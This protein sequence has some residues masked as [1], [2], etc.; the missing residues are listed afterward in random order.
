VSGLVQVLLDSGRPVLRRG[1]TLLA[2]R[3]AV[4]GWR[5]LG[6]GD[7]MLFWIRARP[8][9][10]RARRPGARGP[11]GGAA[12]RACAPSAS[13][14]RACRARRAAR[15]RGWRRPCRGPR[16]RCAGAARRSRAARGASPRSARSAARRARRGRPAGPRRRSRP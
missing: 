16:R 15:A 7:A 4:L 1:E 5:N 8:G 2:E 9:S 3:S 14:P 12:R 13:S 11:R 10:S 6:E